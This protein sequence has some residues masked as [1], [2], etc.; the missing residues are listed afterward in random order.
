MQ[1]HTGE[2]GAPPVCSC[3]IFEFRQ[4]KHFVKVR[5]RLL[6]CLTFNIHIVCKFLALTFPKETDF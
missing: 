1:S 6:L 3:I 4:E 2:L 5:G